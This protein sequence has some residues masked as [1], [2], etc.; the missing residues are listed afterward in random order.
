MKRYLRGLVILLLGLLLVVIG[1]FNA[2]N[3]VEG[4]MGWYSV[5][6]GMLGVVFGLF[7]ITNKKYSWLEK[8]RW[9]KTS[10][11]K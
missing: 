6:S 3:K 2:V 4:S 1:G 9:S 5:V 10:D 8:S 7:D 11:G